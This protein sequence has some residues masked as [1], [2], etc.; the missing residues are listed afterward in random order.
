ML[1]SGSNLAAF[2]IKAPRGLSY[3]ASAYA[4]REVILFPEIQAIFG[5]TDLKPG[6]ETTISVDLPGLPLNANVNKITATFRVSES[7]D[8]PQTAN[9]S[10]ADKDDKP[11]DSIKVTVSG[12]PGPRNVQVRLDKGQ[13]FWNKPGTLSAGAYSIPD[14]SSAVNQYLDKLG[15]K[16]QKVTLT[17]LVKSDAPGTVSIAINGDELHYS[18]VQTQSWKNDLDST[19]RVDRTLKLTFNQIEPLPVDAVAATGA[20]IVELRLDAGG[21]FGPDRLLGEVEVHDGTQFGSVSPDFSLAQGVTPVK[22]LLKTEI[23]CT[24]VAGYFEGTDKAEF[25]VEMQPDQAGSPA[26]G[27]PLAK[28][29]VSFAPADPKDIQPWTFAKF[30][31]PVKLKP[32][33]PFWIVL[34]GVRG[35]VRL[36]LKI[37]SAPSGNVP[38]TR[39]SLLLNRGGQLWKALTS[40]RVTPLEGLLSLVYVPQPDNQTAAVQIAVGEGQVQHI[41][42]AAKATT[43]H[44][45]SPDLN[46]AA[47]LLVINSHGQGSLTIANVIQEYTL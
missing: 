13:V 9:V 43:V 45:Q 29:N 28:A 30:E 36:G 35:S 6:E 22:D 7:P 41:D 3:N 18:L 31:K 25:Y 1:I 5:G 40:S 14:F 21:Q 4:A 38:V 34:K 46:P 33:T 12:P 17:F 2:E 8:V 23:D 39:D 44:F 10:V 32:D 16:N 47:P 26:S 24:G 11:R 15:A 37:S 42:P 19:F 20:K 27:A